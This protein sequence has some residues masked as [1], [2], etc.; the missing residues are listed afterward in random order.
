MQNHFR[1]RQYQ[2][3]PRTHIRQR[4]LHC[5]IILVLLLFVF[6]LV[7]I[8][9]AFVV[10]GAWFLIIPRLQ[11]VLNFSNE[12]YYRELAFGI[13]L[14]ILGSLGILLSILGLVALFTLR[15]VLVRIVS[16]IIYVDNIDC[17]EWT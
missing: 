16:E 8:S 4:P 3:T 13:L 14:V 1:S 17:N 10:L 7:I 11:T 5:C 2:Y 12:V 9:V 15:L 6:L